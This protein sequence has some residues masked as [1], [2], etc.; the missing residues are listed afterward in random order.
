M[1]F[2]LR[3][4]CSEYNVHCVPYCINII[5]FTDLLEIV[6]GVLVKG[7]VSISKQCCGLDLLVSVDSHDMFLVTFLDV[8]LHFVWYLLILY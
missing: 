5:I 6:E 4:V 8:S 1:Q 7:C 2:D 3:N